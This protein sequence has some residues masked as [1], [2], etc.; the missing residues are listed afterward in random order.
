MPSIIKHETKNEPPYEINGHG[1]PFT[2]I[3]PTVIAALTKNCERKIV[4]IPISVK[5][6]KR[7]LDW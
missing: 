7:S 6:E 2:G 5:L 4:A 1:K 3:R